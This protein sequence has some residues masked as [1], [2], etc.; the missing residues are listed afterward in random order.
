[1]NFRQF[2][3]NIISLVIGI[4]PSVL[5]RKSIAGRERIVTAFEDYFRAEGQKRASK[6]TQKRYETGITNGLPANDIARFE[7]GAAIA[8]LVNTA[9]AAFWIFLFVYSSPSL[10]EDI[11]NEVASIMSTSVSDI[12]DLIRSLDI[13]SVKTSCPLLIST[14]QE[15]LRLKSMNTPIRTVMHDTLLNDRWLLK[16]DS[17]IQMPTRII[18]TDA[19]IWGTDVN[20]FNPR[21]FLKDT[22]P[23][24]ISGKRVNSA[25]FRAFG[26][27]TTLCPGRHFATTEI[28]AV[29]TMFVMRFD[30]APAEHTW[31]FPESHH[32]NVTSVIMEPDTAVNVKISPRKGFEHGQW[33]VSLRDS[34]LT[35]VVVTED[36]A[37]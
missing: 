1:M 12:G 16:K 35:V 24:T 33:Q 22:I 27:G 10:L 7:A 5:A 4:I 18:H 11:R 14:F 28:L 31:H 17:I 36:G 37:V 8:L 34:A 30:M 29:V 19:S 9:P 25:A 15:V 23:Q 32:T 2:E 13:T 6:F 21:R 3:S 26:G 20:D